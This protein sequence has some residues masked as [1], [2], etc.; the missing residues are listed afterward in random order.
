M[1]ADKKKVVDE[2]WD[3]ARVRSFLGKKPL[4]SETNADYSALLYAYRSMRVEDFRRFLVFFVADGR[5]LNARSQSGDSL[6]ATISGHRQ[7]AEFSAA[8]R[9]AGATG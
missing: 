6:L 7:G 3:D 4:G 9:D 2:V 1:R 5:D 8:L